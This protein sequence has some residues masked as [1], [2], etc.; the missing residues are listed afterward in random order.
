MPTTIIES[1]EK[2]PGQNVKRDYNSPRLVEYG[3]VANLT[4]GQS[5]PANDGSSGMAMA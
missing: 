3:S 4:K 1:L 5:G 2:N